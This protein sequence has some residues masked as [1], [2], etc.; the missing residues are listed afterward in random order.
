MA[1]VRFSEDLK[2]SI[3]DN[4]KGLFRPRI[5]KLQENP[6]QVA[7]E[8]IALVLDPWV[9]KLKHIPKEFIHAW[10]DRMVLCNIGGMACSQ[11]YAL[12][13]EYPAPR[14]WVTAEDGSKIDSGYGIQIKLP[15]TEKYAAIKQQFADWQAGVKAVDEQRDEFVA[16]VKAVIGAH[17]T[18]APALKAWPPLWD[19][20]PEEYRQRH[21]KVVERYKPEASE[22]GVDLGKLTTTVVAAKIIK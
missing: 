11:T 16:G 17:A 19:L 6:P 22:I 5:Q 8:I 18:L 10:S 3:V 4:A 7:A 20:V 15:D 14:N 21:R 1:V 13:R 12:P 9:E 2:N